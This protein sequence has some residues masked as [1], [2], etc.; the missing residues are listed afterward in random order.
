MATITAAMVK[1]LRE[2]TGAAMQSNM[3]APVGTRRSMAIAAGV[4]DLDGK[5]L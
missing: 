5:T 3:A 2:S 1:D 4:V